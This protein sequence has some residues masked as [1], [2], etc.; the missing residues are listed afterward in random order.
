MKLF[1][2]RHA[3]SD[4]GNPS[5]KDFDRPLNKRGLRDASLMGEKLHHHFPRNLKVISSPAKRTK[6]TLELFF[7]DYDQNFS[8]EFDDA[9]YHGAPSDYLKNIFTLSNKEAVI[10]IG[11]NPGISET[12][13]MFSNRAIYFPTCGCMG[14]SIE[15]SS[16]E[17]NNFHEAIETF[18]DF[19]KKA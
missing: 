17:L 14:F 10:F 9:L 19:P 8:I 2:L 1:F 3:K 5:L 16:I 11:H 6:E 13:S 18:Y 4:W 12:A 15:K 7:N